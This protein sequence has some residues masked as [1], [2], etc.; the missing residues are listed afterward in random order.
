EED[1]PNPINTYGQTK[2]EG[3]KVIQEYWS[4]HYIIRTSWVY[5]QFNNNFMKTML[6]LATERNTLSVIDDQIGTPTNAIDLAECILS[7]IIS[8][9]E[10]FGIYN[11]SN[12]GKCSWYEFAMEIFRKNNIL[13]KLK[14]IPTSDYPTPA[15]RPKYSV[16]D[17]S[18]IKESFNIKILHWKEN[19]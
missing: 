14:P 15:T 7:M 19:L 3:E 8:P 12:E 1:T 9:I 17:K 6:R 5:S 4:K 11:F 13:I 16:L 2:L 18:K 10:N